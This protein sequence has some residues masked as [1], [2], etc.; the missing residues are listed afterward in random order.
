ML[1]KKFVRVP[2]CR[3][4]RVPVCLSVRVCTFLCFAFVFLH[5]CIPIFSSNSKVRVTVFQILLRL[6]ILRSSA[7]N[8]F[9]FLHFTPVPKN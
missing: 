1:L 8:I 2:L 9:T 7:E 5:S 4:V 3:D 6:T